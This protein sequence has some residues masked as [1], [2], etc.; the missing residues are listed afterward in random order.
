MIKDKLRDALIRH[1]DSGVA[2][3][4]S[5]GTDSSLLLHALLRLRTEGL[6]PNVVAFYFRSCLQPPEE[7]ERVLQSAR[8]MGITPQII[9]TQPLR[10]LPEMRNNPVNRCYLC[11][12]HLFTTLARRANELGLRCVMDGTN[13]DD[14]EQYRPGLRALRE[15]GV[16]SP[17]AEVGMRKADVRALAR[18]WGLSCAAKP[19]SPCLATRMEYGAPLTEERLAQVAEGE[20]IL[21]ELFPDVPLRL[22]VHGEKLARLELPPD[23]WARALELAPSI[24]AALHKLGFIYT[25]LD[26]R[27]FR[28]G[29]M[30][31]VI[32]TT[33]S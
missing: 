12:S 3:A 4:Y 26:L 2:L 18:E 22:R 11:K 21:H 17:L 10:D 7:G 5:G 30:D 8:A 1:A 23:Q 27:G 25:T 9:D 32:S 24:S 19:S 33:P 29:S 28:S 16:V 15:L 14:L 31:E 20:R 6:V 13:A